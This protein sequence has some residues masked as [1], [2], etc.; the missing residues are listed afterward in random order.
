[1]TTISPIVLDSTSWVAVFSL[2]FSSAVKNLSDFGC[3]L[4]TNLPKLRRPRRSHLHPLQTTR[5][6]HLRQSHLRQRRN[7]PPLIQRKT[8][9]HHD[10][11]CHPFENLLKRRGGAKRRPRP[12]PQRAREA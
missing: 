9:R 12:K 7:H 2:S 4:I 5:R 10:D 11:C 1:M 3:A 6:R 8:R